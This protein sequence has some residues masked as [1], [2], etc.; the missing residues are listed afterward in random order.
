MTNSIPMTHNEARF[1]NAALLDSVRTRRTIAFFIDYFFVFILCIVAIPL[2][3]IF[4]FA[5]FGA[6]WL[7]YTILVPLVALTY[8][9]WTVG[10][11]NQGTWGMQI[12]DLCLVRYDGERL[13][14]L[15]GI[16]HAVL[17][18]VA[19]TVLTPAVALLALFTRHKR[20]L[21]DIVLGTV[22]VR[23]SQF[24]VKVD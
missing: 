17:F 20:L 13:D 3:A 19:H 23:K 1:D 11:P 22:A 12:M 14:W 16:V 18:W 10:G 7:L 9:A 21:H 24:D 2:I 8:I 15:T 5:T 4:G 6:G